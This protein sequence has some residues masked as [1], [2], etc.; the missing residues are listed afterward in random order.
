[1]A[2]DFYKIV[3]VVETSSKSPERATAAAV[4]R[5][6]RILRD[7]HIAEL[8]PQTGEG[9]VQAYRTQVRSPFKFEY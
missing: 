3:E 1:M 9:K 6:S 2:G 4:E 8:D 7:L 5:A